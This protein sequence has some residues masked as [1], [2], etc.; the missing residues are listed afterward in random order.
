MESLVRH[1]YPVAL[2]EMVMVL[3]RDT[4]VDALEDQQVQIYVKQA[5]PADMQQTLARAMKFEAFLSRRTT[6][7]QLAARKSSRGGGGAPAQMSLVASAGSVANMAI[8]AVTAMVSR[9][10]GRWRMCK[11]VFPPRP[12]ARTV[13]GG[14]IAVLPDRS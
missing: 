1:A 14:G 3:S 12:A 6:T 10:H 5:H 8:V 9:G 7:Y 13:D 11:H 4:F 2:E